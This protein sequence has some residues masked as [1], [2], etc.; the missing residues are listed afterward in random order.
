MAAGT[1]GSLTNTTPG[2]IQTSRIT[3]DGMLV[4]TRGPV[5]DPY[6]FW[7]LRIPDENKRG[8]TADP[9]LDGFTNLQ[10]YLFGTTPTAGN[11]TQTPTENVAGG[12]I[13]RWNQLATG[14]AV[15]ALQE[16]ATLAAGSW[17]PSTATTLDSTV[18]DL[19]NYVRKQAF[20]QIIG[21]SRFVRVEATE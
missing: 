13:V 15:Y 2:V 5:T 9:D 1:Y 20:I 11:G 3:G 16:S 8:R 14:T 19:P 6:E 21:P 4:A 18:Q 12:L 7:A 10:E 17:V